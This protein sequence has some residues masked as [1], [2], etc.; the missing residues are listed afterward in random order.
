MAVNVKD[1][2]IELEHQ[3]LRLEQ[4]VAKLQKSLQHWQTWEAEY[5]GLK[6]ELIDV[7]GNE[8]RAEMLVIGKDFGNTLVDE[9]EIKTLFGEGKGI[10]RNRSQIVDLL[11]RRLDYVRQNAKTI[12]KQLQSAEEKLSAFFILQQPEIRKNEGLPMTEIREELDDYGNVIGKISISPWSDGISFLTSITA[13]STSTPSNNAPQLLE[14]LEK[15]GVSDLESVKATDHEETPP[16]AGKAFEQSV[17][18]LSRKEDEK[19]ASIETR[20]SSTISAA[21]PMKLS[22][23]FS[24]DTKI[25]LPKTLTQRSSVLQAPAISSPSNVINQGAISG[26][27]S[28]PRSNRDLENQLSTILAVEESMEDAALRRAMLSYGLSEVDNIV[29]ELE[30][31]ETRSQSSYS[32]D[33]YDEEDEDDQASSIDEEEDNFGRSTRRTM[34]DDYRREMQELEMKLNARAMENVGPRAKETSLEHLAG[35]VKQ[36]IISQEEAPKQSLKSPKSGQP[37]KGVRFAEELDISPAPEAKPIENATLKERQST[38]PAIRQSIMER[39]SPAVNSSKQSSLPAVR[40][41][42][43]FKT[44]QNSVTPAKGTIRE[45]NIAE[46]QP[47]IANGPLKTEVM[48]RRASPIGPSLSLFSAKGP[49]PNPFSGP[50][51]LAEDDRVEEVP[52]GPPGTTLANDILERP[53]TG[54]DPAAVEINELDPA[55]FRQEVAVEYHRM[56]NRMIQR[57]GGFMAKEEE[58]E[59]V[60]LTEEEGGT[61]KKVSRFMAARLGRANK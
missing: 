56:R 11:S 50:I 19:S 30:I 20:A 12:E 17:N 44:A 40:K 55:L 1:S 32:N 10:Q 16:S 15:A 52:K 6:E 14:A 59:R 46:Q 24:E 57:E 36:V 42:S 28:S 53:R 54:S 27:N 37:K 47:N 31:D 29:A 18:K 4:N 43:R 60:P 7:N 25:N 5:E 35:D 13:S 41:T 23:S 21:K 49:K 26:D 2:F 9:E 39:S 22:V 51:H 48:E 8:S 58:M 33:D 3:R 38:A 61:V 34:G 45:S